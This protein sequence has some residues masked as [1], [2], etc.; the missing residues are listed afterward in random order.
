M[1]HKVPFSIWDVIEKLLKLLTLFD[2]VPNYFYV[3]H[4]MDYFSCKECSVCV[5][6]EDILCF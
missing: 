5:L 6:P 3:F 2:Y 1:F 4:L